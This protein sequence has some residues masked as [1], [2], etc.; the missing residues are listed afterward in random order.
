MRQALTRVTAKTLVSPADQHREAGRPVSQG[1]WTTPDISPDIPNVA[2]M[3]D[4]YLG[5]FHNFA[6]DRAAA[7][8]ALAIYPGLC[9]VM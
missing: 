2:R 1:S 5:G 7:E 9:L 3:Y 6:V 8:R 4:Y